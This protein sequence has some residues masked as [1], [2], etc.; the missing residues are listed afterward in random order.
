MHRHYFYFTEISGVN[1]RNANMEGSN[2]AG[3][4]KQKLLD[5]MLH[6]L[7]QNTFMLAMKTSF[8]RNVVTF[9]K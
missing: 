7:D 5:T 1:L 4:Q 6:W 3:K 2:M 9:S 8:P